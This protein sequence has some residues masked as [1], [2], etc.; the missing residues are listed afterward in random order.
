MDCLPTL[1]IGFVG[2]GFIAHFHLQPLTGV[3]NAAVTAGTSARAERREALAARANE[4]GLGPCRAYDSIDA[5]LASGEVGAIWL[6]APN[7]VRLETM[8]AIGT[9]ATGTSLRAIACEKPL[10]RTL[11]EARE[12]L[13]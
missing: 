4:L 11:A 8:R 10:G 13:R 6:L 9:A 3:R 7:H 1:R 12:M 2:A 5:M